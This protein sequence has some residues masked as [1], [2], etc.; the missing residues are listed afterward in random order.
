MAYSLDTFYSRIYK[1]YD[2]INR[3]FTFGMDQFWRRYTA[4]QCILH[5]PVTVLDL[6]CGTG[7]LT[8]LL[9]RA[10]KG[11]ISVTGF[12][13]NTEMLETARHKAMRKG[14]QS[15]QFIQ[16]DVLQMPFSPASFDC[17][18]IGFGFRNLI[19]DNPDSAGHVSEIY[20]VLKKG[21]KLFILESGIPENPIIRFF[22]KT[23]LFLVLIPAGFIISGNRKAY[24]YLA[25]SAA[26]FF[27]AK[28]S[29]RILSGMDFKI[30]AKKNFFLGAASLIAAEKL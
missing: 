6:C 8:I 26:N 14:Y 28:E 27:A 30:T 22:F 18:T 10:G 21:G 19:Y 11:K 17:I 7:D 25:Q 3:L 16:G 15:I 5:M 12:D 20:R 23:Y 13:R 2:L 24:R 1:H 29:D 9:T 4:Q